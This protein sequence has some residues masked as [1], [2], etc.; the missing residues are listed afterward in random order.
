MYMMKLKPN[1]DFAESWFKRSFPF[2]I[3]SLT[4]WNG[5]II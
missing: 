3:L 2:D 4:C 1:K 5:N